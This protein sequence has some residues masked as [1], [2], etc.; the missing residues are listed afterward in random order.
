MKR[1]IISVDVEDALKQHIF[2]Q[3]KKKETT[4]S[5]LIRAI[6]KKATNFKEKELI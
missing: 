1:T 4:P 2:K 3:A 5:K 6:L